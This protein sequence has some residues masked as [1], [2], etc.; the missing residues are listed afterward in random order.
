MLFPERTPKAR[1]G[2]QIQMAIVYLWLSF[3]LGFSV[4]FK[5]SWKKM[6]WKYLS[7]V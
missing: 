4:S 1:A 3:Y 2:L 5:S 7:S 6:L